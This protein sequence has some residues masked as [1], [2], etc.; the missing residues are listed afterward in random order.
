MAIGSESDYE[1][2]GKS[3]PAVL[4]RLEVRLED[5]RSPVARLTSQRPIEAPLVEVLL[6]V[7]GDGNQVLKMYTVTLDPPQVSE[8]G[9]R[10]EAPPA[11]AA[12][13]QRTARRAK[14]R[15]RLR[16]KE[17]PAQGNG[18]RPTGSS[19]E[20]GPAVERPEVDVSEGWAKR[21][22]YGPVRSGDTLATIVERLRRDPSISR[23]AAIVATWEANSEAFIDGNMNLVKKGAVLEVPSASKVRS[24]RQPE[25]GEIIRRQRKQW[26]ERGKPQSDNNPGHERYQLK[27]SIQNPDREPVTSPGDSLANGSAGQA[28]NPGGSP[29]ESEAE[30][31]NKSNGS[32]Q[33][34]GTQDGAGPD[35]VQANDET[36]GDKVSGS[37]EGDGAEATTESAAMVADLRNRVTELQERLDNQQTDNE[38][39]VTALENRIEGLQ[40]NLAEQ[41]KLVA[42]KNA[43]MERLAD[44]GSGGS[45]MP[46]RDRYILWLVAGVNLL[47]LLA[48]IAL[49]LRLRTVQ[50]EMGSGSYPDSGAEEEAT[51]DPLLQA[52][53]Q[54]ASGELKQARSTLWQALAVNPSNWAAYG[55][56]LDLYEQDEDADQFEEV[57]GRLFDQLGDQK[58]DWQAE[59]RN[60][61]RHLSPAS[62]LFAGFGKDLGSVGESQ[63]TAA[64]G[65]EPDVSEAGPPA[66]DFEGLDLQGPPSEGQVVAP[67]ASEAPVG[68]GMQGPKDDL[69]LAFQDS[70]DGA[71]SGPAASEEVPGGDEGEELSFDLAEQGGDL[72]VSDGDTEAVAEGDEGSELEFDLGL[73]EGDTQT[74]TTSASGE[75]SEGPEVDEALELGLSSDQEPAASGSEAG[76]DDDLE[77]EFD[78]GLDPEGDETTS[79]ALPGEA[80]E[81]VETEEGLDLNLGGEEESESSQPS[82]DA[83]KAGEESELEID[84]GMAEE[85]LG[86]GQSSEGPASEGEQASAAKPTSPSVAQEEAGRSEGQEM[87]FELGVGDAGESEAFSGGEDEVA[88][89]LAKRDLG[90]EEGNSASE[91]TPEPSIPEETQEAAQDLTIR[92]IGTSGQAGSGEPSADTAREESPFSGPTSGGGG[93]DDELEIKL[94]LA[95]AWVDMGDQDSARGLL[96]EVSNRGGPNQQ[97]RAQKLLSTLS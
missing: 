54:A 2:V 4:N 77:L 49:W 20:S 65:S 58:P 43:T 22:R 55:R 15:P 16:M 93:P 23:E 38:A 29:Q 76:G 14:D 17:L 45:G 85:A 35:G 46:T 95:Q 27:V 59:I 67:E 96:E 50:R 3:R 39:S 12:T 97:T 6:R 1:L 44:Q 7:S 80:G 51:A 13:A 82:S 86:A 41:E 81:A 70:S 68:S 90:G 91:A 64:L 33:G 72:A 40:S 57:A 21:D 69:D 74:R 11:S 10:G 84:L 26:R 34:K 18:Q 36:S 37:S 66:F 42:Q 53:A 79:S 63:P 28:E 25:A 88:A 94:D 83:D 47:L 8:P 89:G 56:L 32:N 9:V 62:P 24:Y 31:A 87:A 19:K 5:G 48:V 78:L 75:G 60:R 71:G 92:S 30:Q 52:D 73:D 61:G